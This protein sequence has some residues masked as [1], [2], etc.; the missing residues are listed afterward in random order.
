MGLTAAEL[1]RRTVHRRAVGAV[2]WGM[3]AGNY[4]LMPF[5]DTKA[6]GPVVLEIPPADEGSITGT[7]MD[8]WQSALEDVGPAGMDKGQGA[9][10]FTPKHLGGGAGT[11]ADA[12]VDKLYDERD[13]QRA[14]HAYLWSL[15]AVSFAAW[16]R[17]VTKGLGARNG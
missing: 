3:P 17:G 11:S 10:H 4:D 2:F 14:C 7:V 13:F 15:P 16:Q 5:I 6:V 1:D 8:A 9:W 12:T